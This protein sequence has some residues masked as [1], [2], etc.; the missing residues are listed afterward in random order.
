MATRFPDPYRFNTFGNLLESSPL[1]LKDGALCGTGRSFDIRVHALAMQTPRAETWIET[2]ERQ[3]AQPVD[4]A[5]DWDKHRSWWAGFW[6]RSWIVASDCTCTPEAREKLNGEASAAGDRKEEDG[7]AIVAQSYNVF[8]F[9]MAC[10]SRGRIQ[11]KF[12]GGLFTQQ[13]RVRPN[14]KRKR[15]YAL[16]QP[17]GTLLTH[18]DDRL[19]GR[20][21]TYQNQRLLYWPLLASGD[22]DL[23]KPFFD[24]YGNLLPMRRAITK[25]WFGHDERATTAKT[26]SRQAANVTVARMVVRRR[27]KRAKSTSA[28]ITTI[29]S[30]A[31]W[32]RQR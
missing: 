4:A 19:W 7:A 16:E 31:A 26:S 9:L 3:A 22:F 30:P 32:K 21:F 5:S 17:D 10:Q 25:A 1:K 12:N 11:V 28:G 14:A 2:I 13:L 20:R 23:M 27:R 29:T 15:P 8:R 18:E 24:Y 6:E